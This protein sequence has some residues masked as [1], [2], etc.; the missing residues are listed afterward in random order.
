V[1]LLDGSAV[2]NRADLR[3]IWTSLVWCGQ[4]FSWM[5]VQP[6]GKFAMDDETDN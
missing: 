5:E 1:V 6:V 3:G 4:D 2:M